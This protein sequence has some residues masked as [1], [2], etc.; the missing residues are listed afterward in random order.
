MSVLRFV[1]NIGALFICWVLAIAFV[2]VAP[3][4]IPF[5]LA[6]QD[7][8]DSAFSSLTDEFIWRNF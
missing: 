7:E 4:W 5:L 6:L 8:F 2:A 3:I 1:V